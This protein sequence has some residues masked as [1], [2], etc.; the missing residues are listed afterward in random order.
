VSSVAQEDWSGWRGP[1]AQAFAGTVSVAA[2]V[3]VP[4]GLSFM[5]PE[6]FRVKLD[7]P[8][9]A[10]APAASALDQPVYWA[11]GRKGTLRGLFAAL[12]K[13]GIEPH[14]TGPKGDEA[15]A[16]ILLGIVAGKQGAAGN[17]FG[18]GV[19]DSV[20]TPAIPGLTPEERVRPDPRLGIAEGT[21]PP[22]DRTFD[23]SGDELTFG[24]YRD[25]VQ[26]I[27]AMGGGRIRRAKK[28]DLYWGSLFPQDIASVSSFQDGTRVPP[29]A[30]MLAALEAN[31]Y[32]VFSPFGAMLIACSLAE[33]KLSVTLMN[34]GGGGALNKPVDTAGDIHGNGVLY[35]S[36]QA[37]RPAHHA[38]VTILSSAGWDEFYWN[39]DAGRSANAADHL[40]QRYVT[41]VGP[42]EDAEAGEAHASGY[43][44]ECARRKAL[45]V[46]AFADG[47]GR[48][49]KQFNSALAD[50]MG[51]FHG[52]YRVIDAFELGNE[53]E[54]YF[55]KSGSFVESG[56]RE[57]GRYFALL[58]GPIRKHL[59]E[60]RFRVCELASGDE[61]ALE[62]GCDWLVRVLETGMT[63]EV[64]LW[65]YRQEAFLRNRTMG[66]P[67]SD[68]VSSWLD[69]CQAAG[70]YWPPLA[71]GPSDRTA[72]LIFTVRDL[73]HEVGFHWYHGKD[74]QDASL[75][76]NLADYRDE[77][78]LA[79]AVDTVESL[80]IVPLSASFS[81]AISVGEIGFPSHFPSAPVPSTGTVPGSGPWYADTSERLQAAKLIRCLA[82]LV[83]KGVN[84][85]SVFC[86]MLTPATAANLSVT[87]GFNT[88]GLHNDVVPMGGLASSFQADYAYR[89]PAWYSFRRL[90]WLLAAAPDRAEVL[91]ADRGFVVL[92]FAS[93]LGMSQ[94][95][96]GAS[97]TQTWKYA[98]VMWVDQYANIAYP[99]NH[100]QTRG[101]GSFEL[102][103][104]LRTGYEVL[105]LVPAVTSSGGA[106]VDVN[107]YARPTSVDWTTSA[108]VD[109]V[110]LITSLEDGLVVLHGYVPPAGTSG[111]LE[112]FC[113]LTN[114]EFRWAR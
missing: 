101:Y 75:R 80:V 100:R 21:F 113:F 22:D 114:A 56:V 16:R 83:A 2:R 102:V 107:G 29:P 78:A 86:F 68:A 23:T 82:T 92:R 88:M 109:T 4:R 41:N 7:G 81:L 32:G 54:H 40:Y 60:A 104:A 112:P 39:W 46:A 66:I 70:Y 90:V 111:R 20:V 37:G 67:L 36:L 52:V 105:D 10:S 27:A 13:R 38:D 48:Y 96:D 94:G 65:R 33:V 25:M 59:P 64:D 108:G 18:A 51:D 30:A 11:G 34:A 71:S 99:G 15:A 47:V 85:P 95:P 8:A 24:T 50:W 62:T 63:G 42:T 110:L 3:E 55:V 9:A 91:Y 87:I 6:S 98:Y 57:A 103:D 58:A 28:C 35:T 31:N 19:A 76:R 97:F 14:P 89:R 93:F 44:R 61:A 69:S 74:R 45:G 77:V 17:G 106:G 5:I 79:Q 73:A 26:D 12:R 49:L 43:A 72:E 53:Y 84:A 1:G